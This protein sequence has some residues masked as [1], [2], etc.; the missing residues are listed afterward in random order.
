[1]AGAWCQQDTNER[2]ATCGRCGSGIFSTA[3]VTDT[4]D[5]VV[6]T[7]GRTP[8]G[9]LQDELV[10]QMKRLNMIIPEIAPAESTSTPE[11]AKVEPNEPSKVASAQ[12][13]RSP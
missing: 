8:M 11:P 7:N 9:S 12:N 2:S 4:R 5:H 3:V 10:K 6:A 1:M 13:T